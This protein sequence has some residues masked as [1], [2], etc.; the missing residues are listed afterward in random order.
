[1]IQ[2]IGI[3]NNNTLLEVTYDNI[4]S[5]TNFIERF[6]FYNKLYNNNCYGKLISII[7]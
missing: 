2:R 7:Y 5:L 3:Y 1:M 6:K 4:N